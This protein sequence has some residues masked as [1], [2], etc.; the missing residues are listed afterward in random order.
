ML[1]L[2]LAGCTDAERANMTTLGSA[3]DVVC[4]SGGR[5]VYRG[6]STGKILSEEHSDG[7]QF[8]DQ[9]T[10]KFIRVSGDCLITN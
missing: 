8:V 7:W 2:V 9:A 1:L 10:G 4:Y 5:E 3:G 6:R